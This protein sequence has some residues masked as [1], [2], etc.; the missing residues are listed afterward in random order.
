MIMHIE[1][2][3]EN[4][5]NSDQLHALKEYALLALNDLLKKEGYQE[6]LENQPS[7]SAIEKKL[8]IDI[9]IFVSRYPDW[10]KKLEKNFSTRPHINTFLKQECT[11]AAS[12][13][14]RQEITVGSTIP[15][16]KETRDPYKEIQEARK[17]LLQKAAK[18]CNI[19]VKTCKNSYEIEDALRMY[20]EK[21]T[22]NSHTKDL[23]DFLNL[24]EESPNRALLVK[25]YSA[26]KIL[27]ERIST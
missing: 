26:L 8:A 23:R 12:R 6:Y 16:E 7:W 21:N 15:S 2:S 1:R 5:D 17:T 18:C 25:N 3:R 24:L 14:L 4:R 9:E 27:A 13:R 11:K 19:E 22:N 10:E 20:V